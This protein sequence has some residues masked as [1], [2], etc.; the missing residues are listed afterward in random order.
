MKSLQNP[1]N[2]DDTMAR[3]TKGG[4]GLLKK[5]RVGFSGLN[6]KPDTVNRTV[7]KIYFGLDAMNNLREHIRGD[8][9]SNMIYT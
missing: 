5:W 9:V 1:V 2:R 4:G 3:L 7:S 8:T 6:A